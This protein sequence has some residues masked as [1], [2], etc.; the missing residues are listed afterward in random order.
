M[1][2]R[3]YKYIYPGFEVPK[4]APRDPETQRPLAHHGGMLH[5]CT[6]WS[7]AFVYCSGGYF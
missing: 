4:G 3:I 1:Y 2:T 6:F 7:N 5:V